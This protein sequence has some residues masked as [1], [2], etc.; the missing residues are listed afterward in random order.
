VGFP[1]FLK[2]LRVNRISPPCD[3]EIPRDPVLIGI[4][5]QV[6]QAIRDAVN[7]SSRKPFAWG[8][9][10]GYEQFEA[11]MQGLDQIQETSLESGY[12]RLLRTRIERVLAKNTTVAEDLKRA[13]QIL[14]QVSRCL[15]YPPPRPG[16][17]SD[18][19]VSSS[20]V[21]QEMT[22]L[23]KETKPNGRVQRAQIRLLGA[24]KRRWMLFGQEL[25]YCYDIPGLPQDNLQ[26]E[27][28]FGR[29]RRHQRRI[30]GRKSTR[31]L[32]DFGQAQVLFAAKTLQE[33][34]DQIQLVPHETYLVHR[35]RLADAELPNQFIR[36]LHHDPLVTI[37]TLVHN[38]SVRRQDLDKHKVPVLTNEQALHTD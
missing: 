10:S 15:R 33:L 28:L 18:Q 6:R 8:G 26:L 7:R 25:L 2:I 21:A 36:R 13:H 38:H 1:R 14:L 35:N 12:L 17:P 34:L 3:P 29:L 5:M 37:S 11:I 20:Q 30:S 9:V 22:K 27:S 31:E 32:L 24:L 23:I 16:L 19:K 4:E